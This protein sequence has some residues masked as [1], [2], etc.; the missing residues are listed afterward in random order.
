MAKQPGM[1][2]KFNF[3]GSPGQDSDFY[4]IAILKQEHIA[5]FIADNNSSFEYLGTGSDKY[6]FLCHNQYQDSSGNFFQRLYWS[7]D[8][9]DFQYNMSQGYQN[10]GA[11]RL[12]LSTINGTQRLRYRTSMNKKSTSDSRVTT[13]KNFS[14]NLEQLTGNE[15]SFPVTMIRKEEP[16]EIYNLENTSV[17]YSIPYRIENTQS[18]YTSVSS[19]N[20]NSIQWVFRK[21]EENTSG[22]VSGITVRKPTT[23]PNYE[24]VFDFINLGALDTATGTNESYFNYSSSKYYVASGV[25]SGTSF[26]PTDTGFSIQNNSV[27]K[28]YFP[29]HDGIINIKTTSGTSETAINYN[30]LIRHTNG[31]EFKVTDSTRGLL[32]LDFNIEQ[33]EGLSMFFNERNSPDCFTTLSANSTFSDWFDI[34]LIPTEENV[35][36][37]GGVQINDNHY[38]STSCIKN[39][40][41]LNAITPLQNATGS[42]AL[43]QLQIFNSNSNL[44][45]TISEVRDGDLTNNTNVYYKCSGDDVTGYN[46]LKDNQYRKIYNILMFYLL[47]TLNPEFWNLVENKPTETKGF[48][49]FKNIATYDKPITFYS[50]DTY[51]DA[52][53][54]FMYDYCKNENTCGFCF[55][56]NTAGE[57]IC[58]AD[59]LTRKNASLSKSNKVKLPLTGSE[60]ATGTHSNPGKQ[61][62]TYVIVI[63]VVVAVL[64]VFAIGY[65]I[66]I[67]RRD[68]RK[69]NKVS[70]K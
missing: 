44:P 22:G 2:E 49:A 9:N 69:L 67:K 53:S 40:T 16:Q 70:G 13:Y 50:W 64:V 63:I 47:G 8:P 34:Y 35:H 11:V 45:Y 61:L 60:R 18:Y 17:Y 39:S 66:H 52:R 51:G 25:T 31:W 27:I 38:F 56:K 20:F 54:A 10:E 36:F 32:G 23:V 41:G 14:S 19:T 28:D 26:Y 65:Y 3:R 12:N 59:N 37:P 33:G 43:T 68:E 46:I 4:M 7:P 62:Q 30:H 6:F 1:Q 29:K 48:D 57:S 55:G 24:N 15:E 5:D 42:G 21:I 58:V